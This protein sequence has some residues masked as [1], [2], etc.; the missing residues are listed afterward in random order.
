MVSENDL[1]VV[2][3]DDVLVVINKPFGLLSVPGRGPER[4]DCAI[5]RAQ[6]QWLDALT[7]HRLDMETSGLLLLARGK[8]AQR[9]LSLAFEKRRVSKEYVAVVAGLIEATQGEIDLPLICDWPNRPRQMVDA[10]IGKPSLTH[11][12][13]LSRDESL[14]R[15]RV[16]LTPITGRSHQLRV[17]L[18][19]LGHCILGDSLYADADAR[20]A[21]P[22]LLL[23]A[24]MLEFA[25]PQ[26]G[27]PLRLESTPPF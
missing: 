10:T 26:N 1:S 5:A 3:Q 11:Y 20:A 6:R 27:A 12:R 15:T 25:H 2:Y 8:Q 19:A 23:H 16:A 4:Q 18:A 17:H 9:Q 24:S 13:V 21:A 7:V 22:R 14:Q